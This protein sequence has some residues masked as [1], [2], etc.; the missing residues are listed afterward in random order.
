LIIQK[1][2]QWLYN[3]STFPSCTRIKLNPIS[4][5]GS[6]SISIF[7]QVLWS[8]SWCVFL[9]FVRNSRRIFFSQSVEYFHYRVLWLI[10]P[11][12][13]FF[14]NKKHVRSM[15]V[16]SFF[17]NIKSSIVYNNCLN[18]FS[19]TSENT[20]Q[21]RASMNQYIFFFFVLTFESHM[22]C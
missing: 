7:W 1:N 21:W 4:C 16:H 6:Q 10:H 5:L 14:N 11:K 20:R 17:Y 3:F 9:N 15:F 8:P 18:I 22:T 19:F 2:I 13:N 12:K